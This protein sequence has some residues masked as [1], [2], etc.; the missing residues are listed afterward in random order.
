MTREMKQGSWE[1]SKSLEA[2]FG[3]EKS[4][5]AKNQGVHPKKYGAWL[6]QSSN[7]DESNVLQQ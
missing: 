3:S 7:S 6:G 1:G 5:G 2:I 4:G